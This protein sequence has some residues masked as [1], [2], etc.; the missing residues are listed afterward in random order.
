MASTPK[1]KDIKSISEWAYSSEAREIL[2]K[3]KIDVEKFRRH[4]VALENFEKSKLRARSELFFDRLEASA[5]PINDIDPVT[6][7]ISRRLDVTAFG[8]ELHQELSTKQLAGYTMKVRR[9]GQDVYTLYWNWARKPQDPIETGWKPD[10]KMHVASVSK[11][12]TAMA[13]V[14]LLADKGISV[15]SLV[16]P[17]MPSYFNAGPG[18]AGLTFRQLL[19][20]KSG[21]RKVDAG[22]PND[23]YTFWDLKQHYELGV[24]TSNIGNYSYY[25]G[26][27]ICLRIAM[28]VLMGAIDANY[29]GETIPRWPHPIKLPPDFFWDY[30]SVNAY[31]N[32]VTANVFAPSGVTASLDYAPSNSL[33]YNLKPLEKG[34]SLEARGGAGTVGWW[35]SVDDLLKTM[36]T[37]RSTSA[38]VSRAI[39]RQA[40]TDG[41]GLEPTYWWQRDSWS[42][43][44]C[45]A[46][47]GDWGDGE[48]RAQHC[49]VAYAPPNYTIAVF[50]NSNIVQQPNA[51]VP[52]S[53]EI[54]LTWTV[55]NLLRKH[56]K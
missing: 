24:T 7:F 39:A 34:A 45:M 43:V 10:I 17:Y 23:G 27:F 5:Q 32:Y 56:I 13:V 51:A 11:L 35:L 14:K 19:A 36:E 37:F 4:D 46:K 26:N 47:S 2:A 30:E 8:Q 9:P 28:S 53:T 48:G 42:Q 18:V 41:F 21:F 3:S 33:A 50:T 44:D 6:R 25:N 31:E 12:I 55:L 49:I 15:D 54:S 16:Q 52:N 38:I 20:Q 29:Q 40:L 22:G 1:T